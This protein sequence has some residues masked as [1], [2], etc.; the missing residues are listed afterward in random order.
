MK[1][2]P[3][4]CSTISAGR[5]GQRLQIGDLFCQRPES[6]PR[7]GTLTRD[8][9]AAAIACAQKL[10][11]ANVLEDSGDTI[12]TIAGSNGAP[13][14]TPI[15]ARACGSTGETA[16]PADV[17]ANHPP[18]HPRRGRARHFLVP[19]MPAHAGWLDVDGT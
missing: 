17:A 18:P 15:R 9:A 7:V 8:E 14:T 12:V 4:H 10:L 11:R 13:R 5:R 1:P 19:A 3:T 6:I 16:S 2:S